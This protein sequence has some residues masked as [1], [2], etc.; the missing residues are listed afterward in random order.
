MDT[1][2]I[3]IIGGGTAGLV[4]ALILKTKFPR[5]SISIIKSDTIGII[6]V[7][8]GTTEHW[9]HFMNFVGIDRNELIAKTDAKLIQIFDKKLTKF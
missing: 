1:G 2:K 4:T 5:K 7:G 6:G 9:T 3:G 8:E